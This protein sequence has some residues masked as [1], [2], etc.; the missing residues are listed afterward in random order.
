[1]KK[2]KGAGGS[3]I[4][5]TCDADGFAGTRRV[6][7]AAGAGLLFRPGMRVALKPNLVVAKPASSGATTSPRVVAGMIEVLQD[8]GVMHITIMEGAWA[9]DSTERAWQGCG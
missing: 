9:G 8:C 5:V 4:F 1:M 6:L 2:L 3:Q 7:E